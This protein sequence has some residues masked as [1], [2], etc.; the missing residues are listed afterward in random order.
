MCPGRE[1]KS[2]LASGTGC[3]EKGKPGPLPG[4]LQPLGHL[5]QTSLQ[6]ALLGHAGGRRNWSDT[7][8]GN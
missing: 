6:F 3:E 7:M 5:A 2:D 1:Q 4:W 8:K